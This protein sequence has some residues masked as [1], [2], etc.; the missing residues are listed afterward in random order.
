M[1][2]SDLVRQGLPQR[3]QP[4]RAQPLHHFLDPPLA[5]YRLQHMDDVKVA[6][7]EVKEESDSGTAAMK[8]APSRRRWVWVALLP[9]LLVAGFFA[10]RRRIAASPREWPI[11]W[12][13][14]ALQREGLWRGTS[15]IGTTALRHGLVSHLLRTGLRFWFYKKG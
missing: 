11:S 9:V 1:F 12:D 10:W 6:L 15:G 5:L 14:G 13:F 3:L 8:T 7:E 4:L 2:V